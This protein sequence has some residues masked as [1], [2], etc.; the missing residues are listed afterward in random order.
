MWRARSTYAS[1]NTDGSPNAVCA[2]DAHLPTTFGPRL[3][4]R[5]L[6]KSSWWWYSALSVLAP[7][8]RCVKVLGLAYD[9][10]PATTT[11]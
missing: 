11:T 3:A 7:L 10:H 5:L 4:L 6:D 1:T 2:S 9:P 8:K